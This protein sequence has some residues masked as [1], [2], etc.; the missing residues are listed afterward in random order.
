MDSLPINGENMRTHSARPSL[1]P[2]CSSIS[3]KHQTGWETV[4]ELV[5]HVKFL[6]LIT[7]IWHFNSCICWK[8]FVLVLWLFDMIS[9]WHYYLP[10][11][12]TWLN[13]NPIVSTRTRP[14]MSNTLSGQNVDRL[15]RRQPNRQ[16][17][18]STNPNIN[19]SYV[20]EPKRWHT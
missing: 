6:L 17:D 10:H 16:T 13:V 8:T 3:L 18:T 1:F 19:N 11:P 15:K 5:V 9:T 20:N 4:M 7:L 12:R 14:V 2:G